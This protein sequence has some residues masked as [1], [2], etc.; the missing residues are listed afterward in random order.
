MNFF[1]CNITNPSML[2]VTY[3]YILS[4]GTC[5]VKLFYLANK[6]ILMSSQSN[7]FGFVN[8]ISSFIIYD[9]V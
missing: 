2:K 6:K 3:F 5:Y 7:F 4:K 9:K 1:N 8:Q